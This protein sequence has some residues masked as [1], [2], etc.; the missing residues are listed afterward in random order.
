MYN[1]QLYVFKV[2]WFWGCFLGFLFLFCFFGFFETGF[3]CIALAVLELSLC[4]PGWPQTQRSAC[5]C[6]PSA[7]IKGVLH[8]ARLNFLKNEVDLI[9]QQM[10]SI[11]N[12]EMGWRDSPAVQST[13]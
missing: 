9:I 12:Q 1:S 10:K 5:L 13:G 11:E 3:L 8:H 4:R 7:G 2:N 6:L